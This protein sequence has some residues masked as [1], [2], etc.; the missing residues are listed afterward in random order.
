[1]R[2][3]FAAWTVAEIISNRAAGAP[4]KSPADG[5]ALAPPEG[6]LAPAVGVG[7]GVEADAAGAL[8]KYV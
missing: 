6:A 5:A 4:C 7:V 3:C 8:Y 2:F 1:M